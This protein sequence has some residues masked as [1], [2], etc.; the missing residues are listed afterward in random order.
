MS[1]DNASPLTQK[2]R[3]LILL[4][5]LLGLLVT[6]KLALDSW[7]PPTTE[8]GVWFYSAM[9]AILLGSLLITPYFIKPADAASYA[10]ASIVALLAVNASSATK[11]VGFDRFAWSIALIYA[12]LVLAASIG[13]IVMRGS[14]RPPAQR[15]SKT[16][17]VICNTLGNPRAIFSVVFLFALLAFHRENPREY[18]A[19]SVA[20][21]IF[22]G[23]Q[24]LEELTTLMRRLRNI[25]AADHQ[26]TRL[27][28]V[29]GQEVPGIVLIREDEGQQTVF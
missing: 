5:Y 2:A 1:S 26:L 8:K 11:L 9:A 16:L 4:I 17:F 28:E 14:A 19:I 18:V 22:V 15:I 12:T 13:S 25:W 27:G 21:A 23:L 3:L 7:L 6:S 24:P 29:M 20:W 10:V